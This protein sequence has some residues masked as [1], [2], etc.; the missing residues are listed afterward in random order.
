M[1]T[2]LPTSWQYGSFYNNSRIYDSKA[3]FNGD[4]GNHRIPQGDTDIIS[5]DYFRVLNEYKKI[6]KSIDEV[7]FS[8]NDLMTLQTPEKA[9]P[10]ILP[11]ETIYMIDRVVRQ[12]TSRVKNESNT[13]FNHIS[14]RDENSK[15]PESHSKNNKKTSKSVNYDTTEVYTS[16]KKRTL[17]REEVSATKSNK[18]RLT[19]EEW[20]RYIFILN[21][22]LILKILLK[23]NF[24]YRHK[25]IERRLKERLIDDAITSCQQIKE[26][27]TKQID[28]EKEC[29]QKIVEEWIKEK[30]E[31][32]KRNEKRQKKLKEIKKKQKQEKKEYA[33]KGKPTIV[34]L[35][36]SIFI[37]FREWLKE[38]LK[39][40]KQEAIDKRNK[41]KQ[42]LLEK[43]KEKRI[44]TKNKIE[45]E[46]C[47]K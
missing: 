9:Y 2:S 36:Y 46:I 23:P 35:T 7:K 13:E 28:N 6:N 16:S 8:H 27:Y 33:Q 34:S 10:I 37:A 18:D 32:L 45:A 24:N 22:S 17:R 15:S 25:E 11:R 47:F 1:A 42:K 3:S 21:T 31:E 20:F 41:Q 26:D 29:K 38:S 19:F 44:K 43:E 4:F 39:S 30:E 40:S 14:E 12:R 5:E